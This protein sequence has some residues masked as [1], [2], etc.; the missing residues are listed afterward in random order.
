MASISLRSASITSSD[1]KTYPYSTGSASRPTNAAAP[2]GLIEELERR[3]NDKIGI[4]IGAAGGGSLIIVLVVFLIKRYWKKYKAKKAVRGQ[5]REDIRMHRIAANDGSEMFDKPGKKAIFQKR[6]PSLWQNINTILHILYCPRRCFS[7]GGS[8][9]A[10]FSPIDDNAADSSFE[11]QN[12]EMLAAERTN[13]AAA[14]D[15]MGAYRGVSPRSRQTNRP[16]NAR[17]YARPSPASPQS[18][19]LGT[20][21]IRQGNASNEISREV[22]EFAVIPL[23]ADGTTDLD[24]RPLPREHLGYPNELELT[25]PSKPLPAIPSRNPSRVARQL[26]DGMPE[27]LDTIEEEGHVA[28]FMDGFSG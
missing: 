23:F 9:Q 27:N 25:A 1:T 26:S 4:A 14:V 6:R 12:R 15:C 28:S 16:Q 2:K 10:Y 22:D 13:H 21:A 11:T 19:N 24:A 3:V 7:F 8:G 20:T 17:R 18:T 5:Y